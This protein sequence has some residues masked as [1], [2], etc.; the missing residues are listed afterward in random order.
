MALHSAVSAGSRRCRW[1]ST[2]LPVIAGFILL[3]IVIAVGVSVLMITWPTKDWCYVP[4]AKVIMDKTNAG[5]DEAAIRR[6]VI[7]KMIEGAKANRV[8]LVD[9]QNAFRWAIGLVA[10]E[11]AV[12]AGLLLL[13]LGA[14]L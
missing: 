2:R 14:I 11:I 10:A 5:D 4:S 3:A 8:M 1:A 13:R 6:Y 9:K 12:L 7:D